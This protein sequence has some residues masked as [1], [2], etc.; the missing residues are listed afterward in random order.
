MIRFAEKNMFPALTELWQQS[1]GDSR[2]YIRMFLEQNFDRIKTLVYMVDEKPVSVVYLLSVTY[3]TA[4]ACIHKRKCL[5]LYA[6]ATLPEFRGKGYLG[7]LLSYIRVHIPE[8]VLL[9]PGAESL[10][11]YYEKQ[12]FSMLQTDRRWESRRILGHSLQ[13]Y[14][15]REISDKA[16]FGLREQ[17]LSGI[18][19]I[20]W[21]KPLGQYIC[22]ENR[23]WGGRQV[24]ISFDGISA[25]ALFRTENE[26]LYILEMLIVSEG[27][28]SDW[29]EQGTQI[30]LQETGCNVAKVCLQPPVMINK[31]LDKDAQEI[32]FNLTLG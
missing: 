10:I 4:L 9:V 14:M 6:A 12:G 28:C 1:F 26:I 19:H 3:V 31:I 16:Y 17:A 5:Y 22:Q 30:L 11:S 13:N 24:Q 7:M 20:R 18:N 8:P 32:Y 25:I 23:F 15:V 21:D 2:E 29:Q 27:A